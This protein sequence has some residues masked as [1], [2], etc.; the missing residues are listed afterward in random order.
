M[1]GKKLKQWKHLAVF[2]NLPMVATNKLE[3]PNQV[4]L[5]RLK[6]RKEYQ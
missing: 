2:M 5:K 4:L 1:H 3:M 6:K